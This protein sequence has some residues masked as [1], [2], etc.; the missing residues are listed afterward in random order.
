MRPVQLPT[1]DFA[2]L[3][4]PQCPSALP[5]QSCPSFLGGC[6]RCSS[7]KK[8]WISTSPSRIQP[9][10]RFFFSSESRM[11]TH[12]SPQDLPQLSVPKP[13][14]TLGVFLS[15]YKTLLLLLHLMEFLLSHSLHFS[16]SH[17]VKY[18]FSSIKN[19]VIFPWES[20]N[21]L[22]F[23]HL[24]MSQPGNQN[25]SKPPFSGR[26]EGLIR[27]R[28]SIRIDDCDEKNETTSNKPCRTVGFFHYQA[29]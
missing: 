18:G 25:L 14:L 28:N 16:R 23:P 24:R 9:S 21:H 15:W 6:P 3:R 7:A 12:L 20:W 22:V 5:S 13:V 27:N 10:M 4:A 26:K 19:W 2:E 8:R 11:W 29:K 1:P 17:C